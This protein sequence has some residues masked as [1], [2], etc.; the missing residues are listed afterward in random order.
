MLLPTSLSSGM[1]EVSAAPMVRFICSLGGT[2]KLQNSREACEFKELN[3]RLNLATSSLER[4]FGQTFALWILDGAYP[5]PHMN[6]TDAGRSSHCQMRR[7][8]SSGV[9]CAARPASRFARES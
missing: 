7:M 8:A 5:R 2:A 4:T 9:R 1:G 6:R 3:V